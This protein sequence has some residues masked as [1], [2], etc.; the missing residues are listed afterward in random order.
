MLLNMFE[1]KHVNSGRQFIQTFRKDWYSSKYNFHRYIS[2]HLVFVNV[3]QSSLLGH[4]VLGD[5]GGALPLPP[6]LHGTA[7]A[8]RSRPAAHRALEGQEIS[9]SQQL[10][11]Q[12]MECQEEW[13]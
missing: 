2:L 5:A 3:P 1:A 10:R 12:G 4:A 6:V 9:Q 11:V 8:H 13:K 7:A